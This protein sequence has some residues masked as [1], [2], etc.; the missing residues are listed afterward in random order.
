MLGRARFSPRRYFGRTYRP[1]AP[2]AAVTTSRSVVQ[3]S[4]G[5]IRTRK[6]RPFSSIVAGFEAEITVSRVYVPRVV[7][8]RQAL[9]LGARRV[10]ALLLQRVLDLEQ[11]GEVAAGL[12]ADGQVDGLSRRG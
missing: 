4:C 3:S 12:E 11:V 10:P 7:P 9:P 6:V 5:L 2:V 8:E 1:P